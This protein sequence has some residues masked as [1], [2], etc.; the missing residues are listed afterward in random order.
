MQLAKR[1]KNHDLSTAESGVSRNV[2]R[3]WFEELKERV[4]PCGLPGSLRYR[5]WF[6]LKTRQVYILMKTTGILTYCIFLLFSSGLIGPDARAQQADLSGVEGRRVMRALRLARGESIDLDGRLDE[7]IWQRTDP[8]TD[9]IQV[10]P[11]NGAPAT[12]RTE[13]HI[14]FDENNL[15]MGMISF[16]SDPDG[17]RA[18]TMMRD[19]ALSSGD[20][21]MWVFDTYLDE[22]S[23]YFFEINPAGSMGDSLVLAGGGQQ[24]AWDGIWT[25]RVV[26]SEVG[27]VAEI[28]VPFRTLNFNPNGQGWGVNFQRTVRRKNEESIW[29]GYARNQNLQTMSNAGLVVG[30]SDVSQGVGL[31]LQPYIVGSAASAPGR[32]QPGNTYTGAVGGDL[33]Y[34]L[35]PNLRANFTIN[36]DFAETEVDDRQ[37][38]LTRFPLRFPEKREFFLEGSSFFGLS[39]FGDAFF[40]RRIGLNE[41]QPQ[42]I[43]Y[44]VKLT[45][46]AGAQDIGVLQVRTAEEGG[47]LGED[48]TVLRARRRFLSE[49]FFGLLYTR[50]A[51]REAELPK[52][53]TSQSSDLHTFGFDVRMATRRFLGNKNLEFESHYVRTSNPG[54]IGRNARYGAEINYPND[55]IFASADFTETQADFDPAV[56]FIARTGT[57]D[58][59]GNFQFRP[60]PDNNPWIRQFEFGVDYI[61]T[62]DG[63]NELLTRQVEINVFEFNTHWG[64]SLGF[65]VTRNFERLEEDFRMQGGAVVL[66]AGGMYGFTRYDVEARMGNGRRVALVGIVNWGGYLSGTRRNFTPRI[67]LRP[68]IGLLIDLNG[69]WSRIELPEGSFS[70]SVLRGRVDSQLSPWISLSNTAQCDTVSRV[71]GWQGR[72]RWILKPGNDLYFVYTHNWQEDPAGI[73]TIDRKAASKIVYTHRF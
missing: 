61:G 19:D 52:P 40:S 18:N 43:D 51:G 29:N 45:G 72:L 67:T 70:T 39:G 13:V 32:G 3:S 58:L 34:N 37:V 73:R 49:S 20:R 21:F 7:A 44:G 25:A 42:R 22:R 68:R 46:Q 47:R 27:W 38:N 23:G 71:I 63:R 54:D 9:F 53:A 12:E 48:F 36:T 35:T 16:D 10:E 11:A 33:I 24:R 14:V 6:G 15:Y 26:R 31:D 69:Q 1:Y 65:E 2:F 28:E 64:D 17:L 41:G 8:A 56:G 62:T 55:V 30:L 50:R 4:R 57:K 66:P 59:E 5:T 60:R